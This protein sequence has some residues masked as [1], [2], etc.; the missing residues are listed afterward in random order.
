MR[1]PTLVHPVGPS[2][3]LF[4]PARDQ[5]SLRE[6]VKKLI[7]KGTLAEELSSGTAAAIA[8]EEY[9]VEED[10][11]IISNEIVLPLAAGGPPHE[12]LEG[13]ICADAC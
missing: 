12:Q 13:Y 8:H 6:E 4:L 11:V 7:A 3:E 1:G 5:I 10:Y 2:Y 9:L